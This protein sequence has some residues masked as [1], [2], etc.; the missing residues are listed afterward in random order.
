MRF[1]G[2]PK[3]RVHAVDVFQGEHALCGYAFDSDEADNTDIEDGAFGGVEWIEDGRVSCAE[4]R[5][6]ILH[7]RSLKLSRKVVK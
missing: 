7:A 4:C 2:D 1:L 5:R 3:E 6:A